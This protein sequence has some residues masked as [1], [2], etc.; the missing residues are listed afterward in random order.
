MIMAQ[1]STADGHQQSIGADSGQPV[2]GIAGSPSG[3]Q[4]S[5]AD[6]NAGGPVGGKAPEAAAGG[7]VPKA[8]GMCGRGIARPAGAVG[9]MGS[10]SKPLSDD[11]LLMDPQRR[12]AASLT[13]PH[14]SGM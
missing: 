14:S 13:R 9:M 10:V 8:V 5:G 2:D 11:A 4:P 1:Q 7:A 6:V 3:T 12:T